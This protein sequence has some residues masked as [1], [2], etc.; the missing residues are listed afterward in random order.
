MATAR[1]ASPGPPALVK[2][3]Y[4]VKPGVAAPRR[5]GETLLREN[6]LAGVAAV[7]AGALVTAFLPCFFE[8]FLVVLA[9]ELAVLSLL[10]DAAGACAAKLEP[11]AMAS[12]STNELMVFMM[13]IRPFSE[14]L[15]FL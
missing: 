8:V 14:V 4:V 7:A 9:E 6:Y 11:A 2:A 13:F 1:A 15:R 10:A 3:D 5:S 12:A